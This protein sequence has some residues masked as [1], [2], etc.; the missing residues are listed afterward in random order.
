MGRPGMGPPAPGMEQAPRT[1]PPN[2]IPESPRTAGAEMRRFGRFRELFRGDM[3]TRPREFFRCIN[4]F[5][6]IWLVNGNSFW[7]FPTFADR[8]FVYGFRWRG[9]HWDYDRIN[10]HRILFFSC[11]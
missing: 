3:R 10:L 2:F 8:F 11:F 4:H 9:D 7:F 6:F 1:A 5:T